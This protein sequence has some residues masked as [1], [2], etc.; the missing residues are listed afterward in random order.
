MTMTRL[1][2]AAA[3]LAA[4]IVA[5]G[6]AATAYQDTVKK[7]APEDLP[8]AAPKGVGDAETIV[9]LPKGAEPGDPALA[10]APKGAGPAYGGA[11][12][13]AA[14][15]APDGFAGEIGNLAREAARL[16]RA[17]DVDGALDAI[18]RLEGRAREWD[19]TLRLSRPGAAMRR[20]DS[21][22]AIP[23]G[24]RPA[25]KPADVKTEAPKSEAGYSR[26]YPIRV[27]GDTARPWAG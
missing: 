27:A 11:G 9:G 12:G 25:A 26:S 14:E 3:V 5:T 18:R 7:G 13:G 15:P 8:G 4:G 10:G 16:E 20:G 21:S 19:R 24:A 23:G 17:G 1:K 6:A 2:L 22:G